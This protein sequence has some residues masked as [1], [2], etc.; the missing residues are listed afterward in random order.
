MLALRGYG[1]YANAGNGKAAKVPERM[2]QAL[3]QQ[4]E[5]TYGWITSRYGMS[6][7]P[8]G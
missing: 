5:T 8:G 1:N 3:R 6:W 4:L 7:G 2:Q